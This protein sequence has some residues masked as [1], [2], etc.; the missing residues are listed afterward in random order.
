MEAGVYWLK[1]EILNSQD[2]S[3]G[4]A[5]TCIVVLPQGST[6]P[7]SASDDTAPAITLTAVQDGTDITG[8]MLTADRSKSRLGPSTPAAE[9]SSSSSIW[10][11]KP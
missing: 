4:S 2:Q 10:I 7:G 3:I 8:R 5:E 1:L 6:P 9:S 11:M